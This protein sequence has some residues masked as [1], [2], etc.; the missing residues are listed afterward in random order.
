MS[1]RWVFFCHVRGNCFF[2]FLLLLLMVADSWYGA[3]L[4]DLVF[5]IRVWR[6]L[7][8]FFLKRNVDGSTRFLEFSVE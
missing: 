1:E 7:I 2:S 8:C 5:Y 6:L 4:E 3:S